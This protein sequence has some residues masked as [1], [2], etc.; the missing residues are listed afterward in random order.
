M[1]F[2]VGPAREQTNVVNAYMGVIDKNYL[3]SK[4]NRKQLYFNDVCSA[5]KAKRQQQTNVVN[6]V[7]E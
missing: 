3:N 6:D 1:T 4:L 5:P 2:S 7:W